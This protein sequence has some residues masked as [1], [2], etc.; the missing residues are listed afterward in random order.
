[1]YNNYEEYMR[2]V[3][4]YGMPNTYR[5]AEYYEPIGINQNMQE[6][7]SLYPDIYKIVYPVVQKVCS[8]RNMV[9]ITPEQIRQMTEE[10]YSVVEADEE[11]QETRESL[12]NG[13][14]KNPRIKETRRPPRQNLLLKDLIKILI[15]RELLSA[16]PNYGMGMPM[17]GQGMNQMPPI[18]RP[19]KS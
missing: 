19:R 2:S 8:R 15:I 17:P 1:M 6:V 3:L 16:R 12:K 10:V 14:V 9:N 5:E 11:E 18:M 7:N 4:G 13:D